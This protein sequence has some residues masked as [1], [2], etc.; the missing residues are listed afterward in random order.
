MLHYV[1]MRRRPSEQSIWASKLENQDRA[2][3]G[4]DKITAKG[5]EVGEVQPEKTRFV[6]VKDTTRFVWPMKDEE[7]MD[8]KVWS[9]CGSKP[10]SKYMWRAKSMRTPV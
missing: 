4:D 2:A 8:Y 3:I 9:L 6:S 7:W 5:V 10:G 1:L